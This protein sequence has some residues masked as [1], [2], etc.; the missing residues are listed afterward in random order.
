[1]Y[2]Y[3]FNL[4][5][6]TAPNPMLTKWA[7][8]VPYAL[9][10]GC[11][12]WMP[13][14]IPNFETSMHALYMGTRLAFDARLK[15][16]VVYGDIDRRLYG[17]A[18]SEMHAYWQEVDRAWWET[19]E[20]AGGHFSHARRFS[21][22]VLGRLRAKLELAKAAARGPVERA[23]VTM[24]DDSLS[25]FQ[26]F[27]MM[28]HDFDAGRFDNL[29]ARAK[30]WTDRATEL[31][32]RYKP[33]YAFAWTYWAH[34][35]VHAHYFNSFEHPLYDDAA[36]IARTR[37]ILTTLRHFRFAKTESATD[38]GAS[39]TSFDASSWRVTDPSVD[40][41]STLG[42]YSYMGSAWYRASFD[43]SP[44]AANAP[45]QVWLGGTDGKVRVFVDG[46][47]AKFVATSTYATPE[48]YSAPFTFDAGNLA[49]GSHTV[50]ILATRTTLNELGTGG[51]LGPV[52]VSQ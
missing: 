26:D 17:H 49:A 18:A 29:D 14:T 30:A 16:E 1:M 46:K 45:T 35:G 32:V 52:V 38:L 43:V 47:E 13:E 15:P 19:P 50:A 41:W 20:Y 39:A 3:P 42:L 7:Y 8:D 27:M 6:S 44:A 25:L 2:P 48:G 37:S 23:R 34:E 5:E 22:A 40:S 51:L 9:S 4:G 31:A 21:I 33:N 10:R 36:R 12:Y 11:A 24:A 28:R